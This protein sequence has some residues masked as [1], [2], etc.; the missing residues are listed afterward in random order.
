MD[1]HFEAEDGILTAILSGE[2]DHHSAAEIRGAVDQAVLTFQARYLIF[3]FQGVNFMDSAGI[4][5]VM[6]RYNRMKELGGQ[7]FL[8]H[9]SEYV[10][11]ILE[12]AGVYTIAKRGNSREEVFQWIYAEK[13]DFGVQLEKKKDLGEPDLEVQTEKQDLGKTDFRILSKKKDLQEVG[14]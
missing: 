8:I 5:V 10:D 6:G 1:I 7:V 12:M 11:R 14:E 9:C 4:G 3:D 2:L 13:P